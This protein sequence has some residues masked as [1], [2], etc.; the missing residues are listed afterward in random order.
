MS[1]PKVLIIGLGNPTLGDDG[2]GWRV[3]EAVRDELAGTSA[4]VEVDC[5]AV[6][7]LTLM[8]RMIGYDRVILIDAIRTG[9][10]AMGSI[11]SCPLES[12]AE[13]AAGHLSSA[14]D[15]SLTDALEVG[16]ATGAALPGKV[17]VV[18]IEAKYVYDF[19]EALSAPVAAALPQAVQA[20][21]TLLAG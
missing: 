19:G 9:H 1:Q 16:R 7:G 14:H 17:E 5:L 2:V 4:L 21:L 11:S 8:E 13:P 3:A 20:V 15:V 18:A 12:L 6:G 10:Q